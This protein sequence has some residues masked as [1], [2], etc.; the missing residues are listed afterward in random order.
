LI[1]Y[2]EASEGEPAHIDA[3]V[4]SRTARVIV[5]IVSSMEKWRSMVLP[6]HH[7]QRAMFGEILL[8]EILLAEMMFGK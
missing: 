4:K 3:E 5:F 7:Q 2:P 8:G 1:V 6:H